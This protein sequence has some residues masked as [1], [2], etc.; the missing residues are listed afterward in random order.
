MH[1]AETALGTQRT[2]HGRGIGVHGS[3]RFRVILGGVYSSVGRRIDHHMGVDFFHDPAQRQVISHVAG[4]P[5]ESLCRD[6]FRSAVHACLAELSRGTE[7]QCPL[8]AHKCVSS[9]L[10]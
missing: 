7:H 10:T 4:C 2:Q 9:Q 6:H 5:A 3:G 8:S 1:E